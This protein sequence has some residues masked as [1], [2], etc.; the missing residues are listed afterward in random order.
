M[1][2][3]ARKH[4][5]ILLETF[6]IKYLFGITKYGFCVKTRINVHVPKS[7]VKAYCSKKSEPI[8]LTVSLQIIAAVS[9]EGKRGLHREKMGSFCLEL[10]A[11]YAAHAPSKGTS[12]MP[13]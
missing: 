8:I 10:G 7:Y 5:V 11:I 12:G 4:D 2:K 3:T 13:F 1:P 9:L 6:P